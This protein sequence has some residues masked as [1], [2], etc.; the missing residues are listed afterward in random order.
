MGLRSPSADTDEGADIG[1][2]PGAWS[3]EGAI[4][5]TES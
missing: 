2:A 1:A 4:A 3:A 5:D